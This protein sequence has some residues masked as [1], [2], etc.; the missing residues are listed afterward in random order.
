M[1]HKGWQISVP[2]SMPIVATEEGSVIFS[3]FL[4]SYG[5]TLILDHRDHYYSIYSGLQTIKVAV[6]DE[7]SRGGTLGQTET[8]LYFE[9]RHFSEP[10]NPA[11]WISVKSSLLSQKN[12]PLEVPP[13]KTSSETKQAKAEFE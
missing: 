4:P 12:A 8:G 7:I 6:G 11:S 13:L 1:S 9:I 3:G 2:R 5:K 10:E